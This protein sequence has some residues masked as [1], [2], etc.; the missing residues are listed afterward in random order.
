MEQDKTI[1]INEEKIAALRS[2]LEKYPE[3]ADAY[4]ALA[5]IYQKQGKYASASIEICNA[6]KYHTEDNVFPQYALY[7]FRAAE[8]GGGYGGRKND[9]K[10]LCR[11][12]IG[13]IINA[14]KQIR[15]HEE[16]YSFMHLLLKLDKTNTRVMFELVREQMK[17]NNY[18]AALELT[19]Q[20]EAY[21]K[22]I[23]GFYFCRMII[24]SKL[25]EQQNA[26]E[27][28]V[29]YIA[30]SCKNSVYS[31]SMLMNLGLIRHLFNRNASLVLTMAGKGKMETNYNQVDC[32]FRFRFYDIL[33]TLL[34]QRY[35][36]DLPQPFWHFLQDSNKHDDYTIT[37]GNDEW[38]EIIDHLREQ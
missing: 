1:N 23:A 4:M 27:S 17:S 24:F 10:I 38:E 5:K 11:L 12:V 37:T 19:N 7:R 31:M 35:N 13:E 33:R 9:Y 26:I 16:F 36:H 18:H 32:N 2:W 30:K 22:D 3:D 20:Y 21:C 8:L 34:I 25:G 14:S 15:E 29:T 28:A 6:F